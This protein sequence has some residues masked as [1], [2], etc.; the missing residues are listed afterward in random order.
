MWTSV[1][2]PEPTL[3]ARMAG[4]EA[5]KREETVSVVNMIADYETKEC[6]VTTVQCGISPKEQKSPYEREEQV[7]E[8][9]R[10]SA[11]SSI[12]I[13]TSCAAAYFSCTEL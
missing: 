4:T 1:Q 10:G 6:D 8:S 3:C 9:V 12:H 13:H 11:C 5:K 2:E 7:R